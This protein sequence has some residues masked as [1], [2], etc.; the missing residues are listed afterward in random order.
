MDSFYDT[1]M[2]VLGEPQTMVGYI[3]YEVCYCLFVFMFFFLIF[4]ILYMIFD[5]VRQSL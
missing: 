5:F 2:L 1:F 4:L 3:I